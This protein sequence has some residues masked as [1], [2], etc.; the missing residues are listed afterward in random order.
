MPRLKSGDR[1][2]QSK[3]IFSFIL[4]AI[5]VYLIIYKKKGG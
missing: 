3:L 5:G 2:I 1:K 4:R